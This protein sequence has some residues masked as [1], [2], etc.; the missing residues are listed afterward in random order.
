MIRNPVSQIP[1]PFYFLAEEIEILERQQTYVRPRSVKC[2]RN[3]FDKYRCV[4]KIASPEARTN[5]VKKNALNHILV[6][7]KLV[8]GKAEK[9]TS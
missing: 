8:S 9:F 3:P 4:P 7:L 2:M 5:L 6:Y 1:D